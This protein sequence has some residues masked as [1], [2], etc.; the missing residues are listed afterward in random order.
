[1]SL[2][3]FQPHDTAEDGRLGHMFMRGGRA[4]NARS[5]RNEVRMDYRVVSTGWRENEHVSCWR[6]AR[7]RRRSGPRGAPCLAED[8]PDGRERWAAQ[9]E[10]AESILS[11]A[12]RPGTVSCLLRFRLRRNREILIQPLGEFLVLREGIAQVLF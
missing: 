5:C 3:A 11:L 6:Q 1:M 7:S 12:A 10:S 2:A 4:R 8:A 9:A